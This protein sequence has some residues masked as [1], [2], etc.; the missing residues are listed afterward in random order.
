MS[1]M[2]EFERRRLAQA[3]LPACDRCHEVHAE[4]CIMDVRSLTVVGMSCLTGDE[5]AR[6]SAGEDLDLTG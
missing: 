2:S 6:F 5:V 1:E 3:P 4:G